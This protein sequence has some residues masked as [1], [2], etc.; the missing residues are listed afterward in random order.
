MLGKAS[1]IKNFTFEVKV[2]LGLKSVRP[3]NLMAKIGLNAPMTN[4]VK[5]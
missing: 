1:K 3:D 4:R 2:I 5:V